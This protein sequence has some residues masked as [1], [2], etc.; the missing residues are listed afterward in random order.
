MV[1]GLA[2]SFPAGSTANA[3][4]KPGEIKSTAFSLSGI[5]LIKEGYRVRLACSIFGKPARNIIML[6]IYLR[7]FSFTPFCRSYSSAGAGRG[8]GAEVQMSSPLFFP[9]LLFLP[10][11]PKQSLWP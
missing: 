8:K 5:S 4:L 9:C 10:N 3:S 11:L 1:L 2:R 6:S 7:A